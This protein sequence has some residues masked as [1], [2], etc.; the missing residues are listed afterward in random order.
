MSKVSCSTYKS[1]EDT[2]TNRFNTKSRVV[3]VGKRAMG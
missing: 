1:R 2:W 3:N